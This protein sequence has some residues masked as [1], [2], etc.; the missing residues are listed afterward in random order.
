M[1]GWICVHAHE[2]QIL[3]ICKGRHPNCDI[4]LQ[5][6]VACSSFLK[7]CGSSDAVC[8][9]HDIATQKKTSEMYEHKVQMKQGPIKKRKSGPVVQRRECF[10]LNLAE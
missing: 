4:G 10:V 5:W 9:S 7:A 1:D 6:E 3:Q 8:F 2:F